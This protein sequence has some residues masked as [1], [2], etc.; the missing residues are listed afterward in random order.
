V[1][2]LKVTIT[3]RAPL[4]FSERRPGNQFR[5]STLYIPGAVIRGALAQQFLDTDK[6]SVEDFRALFVDSSAPTFHN[7]YPALFTA[8]EPGAH[9]ASSRPLPATAYTC[10]TEKG[11]AKLARD[12]NEMKGHGV[13]DGLVDRMCCELLG[14][15]VPYSPRCNHPDHGVGGERVE[16]YGGFY[17]L[18]S[19]GPRGV[20]VG[21]RLSTRAAVNRRR[22]VSEDQMLYSPLVLDE[23]MEDSSADETSE[24]GSSDERPRVDTTFHGGIVADEAVR[25]LIERWLPGLTHVGSGV[26]RGFGQ[27][28]VEVE[29]AGAD[30]PGGRVERFNELLV[31]RWKLWEALRDERAPDPT[32][33]PGGGTFFSVTLV[34]DAILSDEGWIP[35][36]RLEPEMLGD[37]GL[38]ATLLRCY[39]SVDYR[40]GWNTAWRLPKDTELVAR[41]GSVYVY[42]T[43]YG[44]TDAEWLAALHALEEHG[45]GARRREGFGE[46]RVCDEFHGRIQEVGR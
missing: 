16:S 7:A 42:H 8:S 15:V 40:G 17:A 25:S 11:F 45:V 4:V 5:P 31:Q 30:G 12:T 21:L 32:C 19:E 18:T 27:V 44:A 43:D 23:T 10:K 6:Q 24:D 22:R 20:E 38:N 29:E 36:V 46:V 39:A 26:S 35:T 41:M 37:A 2:V 13:F 14:V 3:A 33:K 28:I 34:S 9:F 1:P